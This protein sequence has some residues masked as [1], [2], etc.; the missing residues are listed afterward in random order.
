MDQ[1][2]DLNKQRL[3]K[4]LRLYKDELEFVNSVFGCDLNNRKLNIINQND[5][6]EKKASINKFPSY[7]FAYQKE[8]L[9]P[10]HTRE[11]TIL[12]SAYFFEFFKKD[13]KNLGKYYEIIRDNLYK[14]AEYFD[15]VDVVRS[16]ENKKKEY[17]NK[18]NNCVK[19]YNG[20]VSFTINNR[21]DFDLAV[22]Y[23]IN[24][25]DKISFRE[26][27]EKS[28]VLLKIASN[29][30]YHLYEYQ[31]N[32]LMK[33]AGMGDCTE[34]D[35]REFLLNLTSIVKLNKFMNKNSKDNIL[36]ELESIHKNGEKLNLDRKD[37]IKLAEIYENVCRISKV[38]SY[39]KPEDKLFWITDK[40]QRDCEN[41]LIYNRKT[42]TYY[43]NETIEKLN[44]P[45]MMCYM[46]K[47]FVDKVYKVGEFSGNSV[48]MKKRLKSVLEN[49]CSDID[50]LKFDE[51]V[52]F[53]NL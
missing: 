45:L 42:K 51:M 21:T 53:A 26:K 33:M 52:K 46:G 44:K 47:E 41:S 50:L 43:N 17:E 27:L 28:D 22:D 23:L 40:L 11:A 12:S 24:N 34:D 30:G 38:S 10:C 1:S 16:I 5:L 39:E 4:L 8:N 2:L 6:I 25:S 49:E 13:N 37:R 9:F 15:C 36:K 3:V 32:E 48:L 20:S 29:R 18:S 14:S 19:I 31:E 7:L 35:V